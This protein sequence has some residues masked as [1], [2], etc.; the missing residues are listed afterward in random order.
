MFGA[1][2]QDPYP[3]FTGLA[4]WGFS[5]SDTIFDYQHNPVY[6]EAGTL[7]LST[8][9]NEDSE[10]L[11]VREY[12]L[13]E[14]TTTLEQV[15]SFGEGEGVEGCQMGEAHRLGGGN[16]LH[17]YGTY[18]RLREVTSAGQVV[19]DIAWESEEYSCFG[20]STTPGHQVLRSNPVGPDLYAFA[21]ERP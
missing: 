15:W 2:S 12:A 7:L 9:I 16:T 5:P 6:T 3:A 4:A 13:N 14:S 8:H 11:V 19:W 10:E 21:P 1:L 20:G 17:N 18:A